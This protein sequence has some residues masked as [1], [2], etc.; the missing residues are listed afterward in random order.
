MARALILGRII[1]PS[2]LFYGHYLLREKLF[3]DWVL[4]FRKS[5]NYLEVSA[6]FLLPCL[7]RARSC[8]HTPRN[9]K[10]SMPFPGKKVLSNP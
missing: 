1:I 4:N 8:L 3:H 6:V 7:Q 9:S 10:E 2:I 5:K